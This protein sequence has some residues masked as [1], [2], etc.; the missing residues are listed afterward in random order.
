M[1]DNL[2]KT[3]F[4][5][6]KNL[7]KNEVVSIAP[8]TKLPNLFNNLTN[9]ENKSDDFEVINTTTLLSSINSNKNLNSQQSTVINLSTPSIF[10]IH[11]VESN[12]SRI[13][14]PI[15]LPTITNNELFKKESSE[16]DGDNGF[17]IVT[18]HIFNFTEQTSNFLK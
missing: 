1:P 11:N 6:N 13:P 14:I 4:Y 7:S 2:E 8:F 12:D 9:E 18:Q 15:T 3:H 10:T 5:N 16:S 17:E